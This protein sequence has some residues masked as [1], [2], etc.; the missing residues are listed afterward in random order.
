MDAKCSCAF[1]N[2]IPRRCR[3][4]LES[5]WPLRN[6]SSLCTWVYVVDILS[7]GSTASTSS[8]SYHTVHF[9]GRH[10]FSGAWYRAVLT[11]L[12][13]RFAFLARWW[14]L[15]SSRLASLSFRIGTA[16]KGSILTYHV[17]PSPRSPQESHLCIC[18]MVLTFQYNIS[19]TI[20]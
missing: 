13:P 8:S 7:R 2:R 10:S 3:L 18:S 5:D 15:H 14:Y 20:S 11:Q 4:Y 9:R 19:S 16:I 6:V 1:V 17:N 12:F